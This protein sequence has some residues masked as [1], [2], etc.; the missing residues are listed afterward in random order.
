LP[1]SST[2]SSFQQ[3]PPPDHHRDNAP[4]QTSSLL[5]A[6][7]AAAADSD[8]WSYGLLPSIGLCDL[9]PS[10]PLPELTVAPNSLTAPTHVQ[11]EI[12]R[13][14][15]TPSSGLLQ[16]V[17]TLLASTHLYDVYVSYTFDVL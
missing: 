10:L 17:T 4:Q 12:S 11:E 14:F 13:I 3:Q 6:S 1:Q 8:V 7:R 16:V 15:A 2:S 9:G 5:N